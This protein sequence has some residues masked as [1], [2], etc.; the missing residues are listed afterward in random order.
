MSS[1]GQINRYNPMSSE[2]AKQQAGGGQIKRRAAWGSNPGP[3]LYSVTAGLGETH[4]TN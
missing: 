1:L 4:S 2:R 3:H